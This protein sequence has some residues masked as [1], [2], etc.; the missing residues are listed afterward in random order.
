[1]NRVRDPARN[2]HATKEIHMNRT[3]IFT[4]LTLLL[5]QGCAS[6]GPAAGAGIGAIPMALWVI[7]FFTALLAIVASVQGEL[8]SL[9]YVAG[10]PGNDDL[11]TR[12][13]RIAEAAAR[14]AATPA[15]VQALATESA[16]APSPATEAAPAVS[17]SAP[18][19]EVTL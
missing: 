1:V 15:P 10:R 2:H 19:V 11:P 5:A 9:L 14:A 17:T 12:D 13:Q 16:P 7:L 18:T 3:R 8:V 4:A 6:E